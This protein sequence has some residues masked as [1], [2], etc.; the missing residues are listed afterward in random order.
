MP[1]TYTVVQGDYVSR[2]AA[3]QGFAGYSKIWN[4]P[5]N[6]ELKNL[7]KNPE[8]L[9]PGDVLFIPDRVDRIEDRPTDAKHTFVAKIAPLK[10]RVVIKDVNNKP[11]AN[12][13]CQ[14]IVDGHVFDLTTD[15]TGKV[16]TE[17]P[18]TA[19]DGRLT[20]RDPSVPIEIDLPILIGHLDPVEEK[21]GQ[22]ARLHSLGYNPGETPDDANRFKRAIEEFQCENHLT[23]DGICG[24]A[25][26]SK[27]K[28]VF[29][30]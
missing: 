24:P 4:H 23:V 20:L 5:N 9:Y 14:V 16:E 15:G 2:I 11:V 26:Q 13:P 17:I 19:R 25:T 21:S 22:F 1:I 6:A 18:R 7:R 3:Q 28:L 29:G 30:A 8:V 10:L 12:K 27:L